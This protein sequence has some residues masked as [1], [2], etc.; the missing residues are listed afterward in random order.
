MALLFW[1]GLDSYNILGDFTS[2]KPMVN[3]AFAGGFGGYSPDFSKTGGRY[4]G[5]RISQSAYSVWGKITV[6][7]SSELYTGRAVYST[8]NG[9][10]LCFWGTTGSTT[11]ECYVDVSSGVVRAYNSSGTLLGQ[12]SVDYPFLYNV[13]NWIEARAIISTNNSTAD[14]TIEVWLNNRKV[15]SN[16]ACITKYFNA[17]TGFG[18]VNSQI[19][20]GSTDDMYVTDTTGPA[21]LN[22]RLGDC[23][24]MNLPVISDASPNDGTVAN[25]SA[26]Y[27][28]VNDS[29]GWNNNVIT[30]TTSG[31]KELF[32]V[33]NLPTNANQIYALSVLSISKKSDAGTANVKNIIVANNASYNATPYQ[34]LTSF[35]WNRTEY[36]TNPNTGSQWTYS[37]VSDM[38]IGVEVE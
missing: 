10:L 30:M 27:L 2:S 29:V 1:D 24:I 19:T 18:G 15:I 16:T 34:L 4:N 25:G 5:C 23:R 26:H 33:D 6:T 21:P 17:S 8:G 28:W 31:Q 11:P 7:T 20:G 36:T 22:G 32:D 3:P 14:G 12:S 37:Q 9:L 38:K 35:S 13:W